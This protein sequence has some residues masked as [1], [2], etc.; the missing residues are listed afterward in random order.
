[1]KS[2]IVKRSLWV[3]FILCLLAVS[4][5]GGRRW[6][7]VFRQHRLVRQAHGFVALSDWK[8]AALCLERALLYNPKDPE[9][10]RLMAELAQETHSPS[11]LIWWGRAVENDPTS[12]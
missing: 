10:C 6:Y 4:C 12:F 3:V 11:A 8:N 7:R 9:A 5:Y 2:K 1:M